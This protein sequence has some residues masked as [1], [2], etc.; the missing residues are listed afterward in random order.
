MH[1]LCNHIARTILYIQKNTIGNQKSFFKIHYLG[2]KIL[3]SPSQK[4]ERSGY[5]CDGCFIK[6]YFVYYHFILDKYCY[7]KL[8]FF[9]DMLQRIR[10]R[11]I[12]TENSRYVFCFILKI[13]RCVLSSQ[14]ISINAYSRETFRYFCLFELIYLGTT[15]TISI[16]FRI[17]FPKSYSLIFIF[18]S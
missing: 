9:L 11:L 10:S 6:R 8:I 4:F 17:S 7:E 14:C 5:P 3:H 16:H 15:K 18:F 1:S 2:Q 12:K 13:C